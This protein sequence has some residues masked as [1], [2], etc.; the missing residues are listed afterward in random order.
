M[1]AVLIV[2]SGVIGNTPLQLSESRPPGLNNATFL[3]NWRI[4]LKQLYLLRGA[5]THVYEII[6]R[7]TSVRE[8]KRDHELCHPA[9]DLPS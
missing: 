6:L 7:Q 8:K 3:R 5:F 4:R 2:L 9:V 1:S